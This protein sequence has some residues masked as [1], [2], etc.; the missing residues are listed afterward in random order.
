MR[1]QRLNLTSPDDVSEFLKTKKNKSEFLA[2]TVREKAINDRKKEIMEK[3][4]K[5]KH[6]YEYDEDFNSL[7]GL[8]SQDF[9]D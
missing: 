4:M 2:A 8:D 6:Y 5:L 3:A 7:N 9:V 1:T